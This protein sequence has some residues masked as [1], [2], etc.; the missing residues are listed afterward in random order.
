MKTLKLLLTFLVMTINVP[1]LI[2]QEV[3]TFGF[4]LCFKFIDWYFPELI[5]DMKVKNQK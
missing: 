2:M 4:N 3:G 1:F 5:E